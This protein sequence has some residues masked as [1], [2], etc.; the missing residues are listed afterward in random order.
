MHDNQQGFYI[1]SSSQVYWCKILLEIVSPQLIPAGIME[2][3]KQCSNSTW[4]LNSRF[5]WL[6]WKMD[7]KGNGKLKESKKKK[8]RNIKNFP[9]Y[10]VNFLLETA[11]DIMFYLF[12]TNAVPSN[13]N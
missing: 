8:K 1:C 4:R 11:C 9:V 13:S 12:K 7:K 3:I 2:E 6:D 5:A 10:T